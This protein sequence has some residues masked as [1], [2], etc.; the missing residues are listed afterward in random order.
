MNT[1]KTGTEYERM[2]ADYLQK[3]GIRILERNYR[4]RNGEIDIIGRDQEYLIFF[5]VKYR[6][7]L[8]KLL[9]LPV[10]HFSNSFDI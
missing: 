9:P 10:F 5:E 1:R 8:K 6:K 4:N 2:A 3:Q 7:S